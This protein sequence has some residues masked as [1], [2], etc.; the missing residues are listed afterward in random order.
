MVLLMATPGIKR[1]LQQ[2]DP[3]SPLL[4]LLVTDVSS[5]MFSHALNSRILVRVPIGDFGSRCNLHYA[6]DLLIMT[7]GG[8][9]DLRIVK[10]ILFLIEGMSG[11]ATNFAK[12][13][14]NSCK[15]G[16]FRR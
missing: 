5:V 3:L 11:L 14:L 15:W 1:G 9:E 13:C 16:C 2:G 4:F 10:L 8:L 6:D 12:T 7:T